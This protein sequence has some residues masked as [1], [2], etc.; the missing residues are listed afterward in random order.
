M[1]FTI[2]GLQNTM[3]NNGFHGR[4]PYEMSMSNKMIMISFLDFNNYKIT[5]HNNRIMIVNE[6]VDL[7]WHFLLH[8]VFET[9]HR[10]LTLF[11]E[12]I[13]YI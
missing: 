4:L 2:K 9:I 3:A 7:L 5:N 12:C 11:I 6:K 8:V 13:H 10:F 1:L